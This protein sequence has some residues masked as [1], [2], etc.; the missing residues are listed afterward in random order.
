MISLKVNGKTLEIV[1]GS[2]IFFASDDGLEFYQE[3]DHIDSKE[4]KNAFSQLEKMATVVMEQMAEA[5]ALLNSDKTQ[6]T[7]NRTLN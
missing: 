6:A 1:Q 4:I 5:T 7:Q 3:W 2:H